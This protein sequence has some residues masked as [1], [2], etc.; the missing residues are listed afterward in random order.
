MDWG[1]ILAVVSV[2]GIPATTGVGVTLSANTIGEFKLAR[3]CFY[4]TAALMMGS[5]AMLYSISTLP[6]WA[7]SGLAA[8]VGAIALGG[9]V[10]V[11]DWVAHK[12]SATFREPDPAPAIAAADAPHQSTTPT[13]VPP[14]N[15]ITQREF[16]T[17][18]ARELLD[19]YQTPGLSRL[20]A[21]KLLEPYVG[22]WIET[23]SRVINVLSDTLP[24]HTYGYFNDPGNAEIECRFGPQWI[25]QISRLQPGEKV[26][27]RGKIRSI[28]N[29]DLNLTDC[30]IVS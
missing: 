25:K 18:S 16:T 30:E 22:L 26:R 17:R 21:S 2:V 11:L 15:A 12:E 27:I 28:T 10:C 5:G 1:I 4:V 9:L 3:S 14:P 24:D 6:L 29:T 7:R 13:A 20:Q 8:L 23:D 19:V